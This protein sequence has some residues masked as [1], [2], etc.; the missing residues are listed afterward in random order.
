[1]TDLKKKNAAEELVVDEG[2]T[3]QENESTAKTI[4]NDPKVPP[5]IIPEAEESPNKE[6]E[7]ENL[8]EMIKGTA[9]EGGE[10]ATEDKQIKDVAEERLPGVS[11]SAGEKDSER[12]EKTFKTIARSLE[13][14]PIDSINHFLKIPDYVIA[15]EAD[16]PIV[17]RTPQ[18]N[19]CIE[20]W[21]LI[22]AAI[23]EGKTTI[24]C[25]VDELAV[26]SD[27]ELCLRKSGIR[28]LTRGGTYTYAEMLRNTKDLLA[29]F[30]NSN[31]ELR[32]YGHGER[33]Y[34]A[35]FVDNG[36]EDVRH[37]LAMRLGK[38]RDT[39]N[40]FISHGEY[41]SNE[42]LKIFIAKGAP[43]DFFV[44][45]QAKK[46][47][48][49]KNLKGKKNCSHGT[50]T[51]AISKF[52]LA[53][54]KEYL[55]GQ[56]AK[57]NG[58]PTTTPAPQNGNQPEITRTSNPVDDTGD[59]DE[60]TGDNSINE[61]ASPNPPS[62][63]NPPEP[64]TV[65]TIRSRALELAQRIAADLGREVTLVEM[66]RRLQEELIVITGLLSSIDS[67]TSTEE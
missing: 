64:M 37:I 50:I 65:S 43:K 39:V 66:K 31:E 9:T 47:I 60:A 38:D 59:N 11:G 63:D 5:E 57:K 21:T 1:M 62:Q 61:E 54:F 22:E 36:E 29:M 30:L 4:K 25:E 35:G 49:V 18:G 17:L 7:A 45:V 27:K 51:K 42:A 55:A 20:A 52:M 14:L 23:S 44:R 16:H 40:F 32:V 34:G 13:E 6:C 24:L 26:H 8:A 48:E 58:R 56:E 67:L 41:L 2:T 28:S 19:H 3:D 15:T 53:E 12:D 10:S 46:R 33:R